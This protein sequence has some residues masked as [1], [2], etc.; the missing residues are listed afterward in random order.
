MRTD[1]GPNPPGNP[2][3]RHIG[4]RLAQR[5]L[6]LGLAASELD[7]ALSVSPGSTA[8]FET[9]ERTMSVAQVFVLSGVLGVP[10][11]YFFEGSDAFYSFSSA[12]NSDF[13]PP[14]LFSEVEHFLAE[15]LQIRNS[16]VRRDILGLVKAASRRG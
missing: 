10:V 5:R 7:K 14:E 2:L 12:G 3:D 8:R 16:K 11:F 15:F 1:K 4:A 6:E 9:G 13:P